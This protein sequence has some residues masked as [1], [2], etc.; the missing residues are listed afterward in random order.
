MR[1]LFLLLW[2]TSLFSQDWTLITDL[3]YVSSSINFDQQGNRYVT[4]QQG[5]VLKNQDTI[6]QVPVYYW[7]ECGLVNCLPNENYLYLH[8]TGSDSIQRVIRYDTIS[9]TY[10]TLIQVPYV[11]NTSI[12]RGGGLVIVD[13][14]LYSSFGYGTI[15]S[16]AQD[17]STY[18][19]KIIKT[20]LNLMTNEIYSIGLRNPFRIA[21]DSVYQE[22]YIADVGSNIAEE[23]NVAWGEDNFGW[24]Y[25]EG[26]TC[27]VPPGGCEEFTYPRFWYSQQQ[28]RYIIGGVMFNQE[29]Y[30]ADGGS[31]KGGHI[32]S[33]GN[34]TQLLYPK[35]LTGMA[36]NPQ[37]GRL[38]VVDWIG[39]VFRY[40]QLPLGIDDPV[41]AKPTKKRE[42]GFSEEELYEIYGTSVIDVS[43]RVYPK[44]PNQTG[45]YYEIA[46]R[47][48]IIIPN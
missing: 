23:I 41:Y 10:D 27:L 18:R 8:V 14:I 39:H 1:L 9:Q 36:V 28:P 46:L 19:G 20:D 5:Y 42:Y 25:Q 40:E 4:L 22:L 26:D 24:P 37:D 13:T 16:D 15:G 17:M 3:P 33:M 30:W 31:G 38:Y 48:W 32:D 2:S 7:N 47:R 21:W 34:N 44:V 11:Q 35:D 45:A 6:L 29:Y 12:H 43:G